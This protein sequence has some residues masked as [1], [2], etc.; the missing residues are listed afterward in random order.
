MCPSLSS[1][2]LSGLISLP[3]IRLRSERIPSHKPHSLDPSHRPPTKSQP[4]E[5]TAAKNVCSREHTSKKGSLLSLSRPH[6]LDHRHHPQLTD[7]FQTQTTSNRANYTQQHLQDTNLV[8][9]NP[10]IGHKLESTTDATH[11]NLTT[12]LFLNPQQTTESSS[13]HEG[14]EMAIARLTKS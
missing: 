12:P 5:T 11:K 1:S 7:A 4:T 13:I 10:L 8:L 14:K 3:E 6:G 2:R 9:L